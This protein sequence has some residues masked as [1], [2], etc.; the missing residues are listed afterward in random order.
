MAN[1]FLDEQPFDEQRRALHA[2]LGPSGLA[3]L[4]DGGEIDPVQGRRIAKMPTTVSAGARAARYYR[5]ELGE[6]VEGAAVEPGIVGATVELRHGVV[7]V[8]DHVATPDEML[9]QYDARE[10]AAS[11]SRALND[12]IRGPKVH[13]R[14]RNDRSGRAKK[15]EGKPLAQINHALATSGLEKKPRPAVVAGR[16]TEEAKATLDADESA[17]NGELLDAVGGIMAKTGMTKLQVMESLQRSAES[18]IFDP[19]VAD[20]IAEDPPERLTIDR[21]IDESLEAAHPP[22]TDRDV[23]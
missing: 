16:V 18:G 17:S 1:R 14:R 12:A 8:D 5:D 19:A 7:D 11:D 2:A 20:A 22:L 4:L 9:A 15:L 13:G 3:H 6:Y 10:L 21:L 23:A